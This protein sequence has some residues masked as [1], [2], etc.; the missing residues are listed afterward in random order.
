MLWRHLSHGPNVHFWYARDSLA[1]EADQYLS[2]LIIYLVSTETPQKI[3]EDFGGDP[4]YGHIF[5]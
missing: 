4:F 1:V 5:F 3:L 2:T